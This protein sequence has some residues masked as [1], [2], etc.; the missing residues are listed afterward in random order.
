[1]WILD[2]YEIIPDSISDLRA[3]EKND[4]VIFAE[5]VKI[6]FFKHLLNA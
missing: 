6:G 3:K 2:L 4:S 5:K 1:M